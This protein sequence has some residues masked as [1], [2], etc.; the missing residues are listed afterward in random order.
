IR[1]NSSMW[2]HSSYEGESVTAETLV[3]EL[4]KTFPTEN[5]VIIKT[6]PTSRDVVTSLNKNTPNVHTL[7]NYYDVIPFLISYF[8]KTNHNICILVATEIWPTLLNY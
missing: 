3:Q 8:T 6:T 2:I 5:F 7:Y 1:L 4:L